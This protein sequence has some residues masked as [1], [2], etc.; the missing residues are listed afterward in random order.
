MRS[1][2]LPFSAPMVRAMLA[3]IKTET[4]RLKPRNIE[5]GDTIWVKE[6]AYISHPNFG[7]PTDATH[8]DDDGAPRVVC[9]FA[10][11]GRSEAA[12]DYGIKLRPAF[13]MPRWASRIQRVVTGVRIE[14]LHD[15]TGEGAFAEGVP[16]AGRDWMTWVDSDGRLTPRHMRWYQ[17]IQ[18]YTALWESLHG[19]GSWDANPEVQVISWAKVPNRT[20]GTCWMCFGRGWVNHD[21][22]CPVCRSGR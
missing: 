14:R 4:R 10:D 1:Y 20:T 5:V 7:S 22:E 12:E 9:Y 16:C 17:A 8:Q 13:L 19:P 2:G 18:E 6:R 15:I 21:M 3:G 11:H